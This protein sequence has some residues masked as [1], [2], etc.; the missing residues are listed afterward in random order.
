MSA[1]STVGAA[2]RTVR[3]L[4]TY[5]LLFALVVI[6]AVGLSGLL[7]RLLVADTVLATADVAGLA[8]SLAFALIGGPLAALLWW[9]VWR[10]LNDEAERA[11]VGWGLYVTGAYVVSLVLATSNLL[12]TVTTLIGGRS[13]QWRPSLAT[14]LVWAAVWVWHRW[15]WRHPRKRPV[16]IADAPTVLSSYIGLVIGVSGAVSA[17][18]VLLDAALRGALAASTVGKPWW[19]SALQSLVWAVG[20]GLVWWWHW[21]HDGGRH[22]RGDLAS[23]GLIAVGVLGAGVLTLG[24]AGVTVFVL[25][26]LAFDRT[27]PMNQLLEPLAP[28]I[29]A[30][31][32]GSLV[33]VYHRGLARDSSE[34]IRQGSRLV[35]S[36]VALVAAASGIGVIVN[37]ALAMAATPLAGFGARTLLLG[38]ISSLLVGGVVWWLTWKPL[39]KASAAPPSPAGDTG[40]WQ[41]ARRIYLIVVFGLSAVVA[42][43]TLL[44]IGYRM[45][46]YFL[47]D[48]SGGSVVDRIRAP[49]GLLVATGL[50]AGYHFAVWRHERA[51]LAA[52]QPARKRTIGHVVLVTGTDPAPLHRAI[53]DAT[54][55]GVTVWRRAD[56]AAGAGATADDGQL[57]GRLAGELQGVTGKQVLVTVSPDGRIDVIP[58][59]G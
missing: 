14:G 33:W 1:D 54:G 20:G 41:N 19:V 9:V 39:E 30:A 53:E 25:L 26:R 42:V 59:L 22:L 32:L 55:A 29:A 50:V 56:V 11:S 24:G 18:S 23:V 40:N 31:A 57:A 51:V 10:R 16:D 36:G 58:L 21:R 52:A 27:E 6:A 5:V 2:Q 38:G 43:I 46:E 7:G 28:A 47:G 4:I 17:L 48:I 37:A 13:L 34:A 49:L 44:V 15:M 12:S 35:T 8:R 45:F 3:R